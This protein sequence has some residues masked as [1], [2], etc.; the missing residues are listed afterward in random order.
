MDT[1]SDR[2]ESVFIGVHLWLKDRPVGKPLIFANWRES[3]RGRGYPIRV[4]SRPFVV[5]IFSDTFRQA[6]VVCARFLCHALAHT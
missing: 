2:L 4:N 3:G 6:R 5:Q 1:H